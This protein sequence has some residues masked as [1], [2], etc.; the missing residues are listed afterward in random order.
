M[1]KVM[2]NGIVH[3]RVFASMPPLFGHLRALRLIFG[4]DLSSLYPNVLCPA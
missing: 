4:I 2:L 3:R 1:R